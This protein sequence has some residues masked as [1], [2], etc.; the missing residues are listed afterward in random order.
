MDPLLIIVIL[1]ILLYGGGLWY[2]LGGILNLL[3]VVCVAIL[4]VR[5]LTGRRPL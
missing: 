4:L 2:G 3:L 5:L 1:L